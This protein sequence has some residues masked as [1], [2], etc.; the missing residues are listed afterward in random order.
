MITQ[1][2]K[3]DDIIYQ[4]NQARDKRYRY[5][6]TI[7]SSILAICDLWDY[8]M[9]VEE[10]NRVCERAISEGLS[11][12]EGWSFWQAVDSAR[13]YWNETYPDKR[14]MSFRI[15]Y[16]SR[17]YF[18][19][20]SYGYSLVCGYQGNNAYNDDRRQDG[21]VSGKS[22]KDPTYGHCIRKIQNG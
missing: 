15:N 1:R 16:G 3:Q 21:I 10:L 8:S 4:K 18:S 2:A 11:I 5:T 19:A 17:E 22:F 6:C 20:L 9:P 7:T 13:K 14:V 12:T